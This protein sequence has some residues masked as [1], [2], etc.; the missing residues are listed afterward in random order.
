MSETS[1]M[2]IEDIARQTLAAPGALFANIL[3]ALNTERAR[4][5]T[6]EARVEELEEALLGKTV[7]YDELVKAVAET[8]QEKW[9][10][11]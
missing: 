7:L 1:Q 2:S 11:R 6:L 3:K 5:A 9:E 8:A 10:R 4:I